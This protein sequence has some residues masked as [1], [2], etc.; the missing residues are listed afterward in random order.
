MPDSELFTMVLAVTVLPVPGLVPSV[1][2]PMP[3][4]T[5]VF[6]K[7]LPLIVPLLEVE[8]MIPSIVL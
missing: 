4:K 2:T 7:V 5:N 1:S 8:A 3:S 6:E